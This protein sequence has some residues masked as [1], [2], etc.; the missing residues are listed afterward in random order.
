MLYKETS[1]TFVFYK[2]IYAMIFAEKAMITRELIIR[3]IIE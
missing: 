3:G 1:P 2:A